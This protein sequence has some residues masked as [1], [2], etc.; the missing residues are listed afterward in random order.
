[1]PDERARR[2]E[3]RLLTLAEEVALPPTPDIATAVSRRLLHERPDATQPAALSS[4]WRA[5]VRPAP[6]LLMVVL[7][8]LALGAGAAI[9]ASPG[10]RDSF[11]ELIGVRGARIQ[12][13][14]KLP[15]GP[16]QPGVELG[17][18]TSLVEAERRADFPLRRIRRPGFLAPDRVHLRDVDG[19]PIVTFAFAP[20]R[21]L[22]ASPYT[23]AG[24]LFTQFRARVDDTL[25]RKLAA[26]TR[27]ERVRVT[28]AR[29]YWLE[30]GRHTISYRSRRGALGPARLA[31]NVLIWQRGPVTLRL[32]GEFS[33]A[34]A[35]RLARSV[36]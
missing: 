20:R 29:G 34:R 13:V 14:P 22:T 7:A 9:A 32:E 30:G 11:L 4:R 15:A 28:R 23:G 36:R 6:R 5:R 33:K 35:L 18:R 25:L 12:E 16:R 24:L 27:V 19:T 10:L 31:G 17:P 21:T 26:G 3:R 1:M 2:T 8:V